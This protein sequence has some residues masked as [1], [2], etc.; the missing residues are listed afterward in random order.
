MRFSASAGQRRDNVSE[1]KVDDINKNRSP[2]DDFK[3]LDLTDADKVAMVRPEDVSIT[4]KTVIKKINPKGEAF[5]E[6]DPVPQIRRMSDSTRARELEKLKKKSRNRNDF[7]TPYGKDTPEGE[8]VFTP[9]KFKKKKRT[10]RIIINEFESP[11]GQK[12]ITDIVPSP[13]AVEATRPVQPAP[14]ADKTEIDLSQTRGVENIDVYLSQQTE[15]YYNERVKEKRT[16]RIV[17]FN[18]YGDVEDV[19]L[20][21]MELKSIIS[22]R[23]ILLSLLCIFSLYIMLC[24]QFRLPIVDILSRKNIYSYLT[25]HLITG[26]L[27]VCTSTAVISKGIKNLFKFKADSD[28]MT[29]VTAISCITALAAAFFRPDMAQREIIQVY[30]PVGIISLLFNAI[31][32]LLILQRAERNFDFVSS[33]FD[34]HGVVYVRNEERAERLTRGTLGDFPILAAMRKTDF[35]TD[36]LRYTYSSDI[37]DAF[38][39][40]AVPICLI[41]SVLLSCVLTFI[42]MGTLLSLDA[43]AF[44][45]AIYNML[46]CASSCIGLPLAVN[47]PL[48][49]VSN[50]T[51]KNDGILL[52]YQSVD[53]LYDANSMLIDAEKLFPDD[54]LKIAGV[55]IFA[56]TKVGEALLE[57]A[58]IAYYGESILK[59]LFKDIVDANGGRVLNVDNFAYEEGGFC[60]W[61]NNKRVLLGGRELMERHSIEGIPTKSKEAE[62]A[63]SVQEVIYLS[64]SGNAAAMFI[65][66]IKADKDIKKS[67]QKLA[68]NKVYLI[69]KSVDSNLNAKKLSRLFHFPQEMI[70]IIPNKLHDDFDKETSRTIR[71]SASMACTGKFTSFAQLILGTKIIQSSAVMGLIFQTV[72]IIVGFVVSLVLILSKS[73]E[74]D[75]IYMSTSAMVLYNLLCALFTGIAVSLKKL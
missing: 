72:S 47:I 71:M 49:R 32:K 7:N 18:Y 37:T 43:L 24:N 15:E 55:K 9:P 29:A 21:I 38:S 2:A 45:T 64:V 61:I 33:S 40:K 42:R 5:P 75:Y 54:S 30:M 60:G 17:D 66:D 22:S 44:G 63:A 14:R 26:I 62:Y 59:R 13:R 28:S 3:P 12:N 48:E 51:L 20:D 39:K 31:G 58:S 70:R 4:E 69:I 34:R 50:E 6:Q 16:K 19:G 74:N 56:N 41:F 27:A 73:F 53:D 68:R 46:I 67:M 8:Y 23:V 25:A 1:N 65:I 35:L 11:E 52:G 36:F 57:A 10:R